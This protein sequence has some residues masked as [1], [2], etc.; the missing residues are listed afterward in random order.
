MNRFGLFSEECAWCGRWVN[1]KFH[2]DCPDCGK[3]V[4]TQPC[5]SCGSS[6]SLTG[7]YCPI[8]NWSAFSQPGFK[9]QYIAMVVF[10]IV[11]T[12]FGFLVAM[13]YSAPH[14]RSLYPPEEMSALR[15]AR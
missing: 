9:I 8:C 11:L 15:K 2:H 13:G 3:N 5:P 14:S 10:L 6:I 12:I 1:R 4:H 7:T